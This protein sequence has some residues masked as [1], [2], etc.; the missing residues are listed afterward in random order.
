MIRGV[1][2]WRVEERFL[3]EFRRAPS[4]ARPPP[5]ASFWLY[6]T[7]V[8]S[9]VGTVWQ[10]LLR[11]ASIPDPPPGHG[12]T[13]QPQ[14]RALSWKKSRCCGEEMD[15][16]SSAAGENCF[17]FQIKSDPA[18]AS[19]CRLAGIPDH[20]H[21]PSC[22]AKLSKDPEAFSQGGTPSWSLPREEQTAHWSPSLIWFLLIH[23]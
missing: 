11:T 13:K 7:F 22:S 1:C 17:T 2:F 6:K 4:P 10:C 23:A 12:N 3:L 15:E 19:T 16:K 5:R 21:T 18:Q 9:P 14:T 8:P 20:K